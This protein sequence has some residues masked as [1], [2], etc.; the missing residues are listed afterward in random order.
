MSYDELPIAKI[1]FRKEKEPKSKSPRKPISKKNTER[2]AKRFVSD[3]GGTEYHEFLTSLPCDVCGVE[4]FTVAAH[5]K[6]RGAGGKA[7][8]TAPLCSTKLFLAK[9]ISRVGCHE[10]FDAHDPEIRKQEPRLR[11]LA[12]A[13]R[14]AFQFALSHAA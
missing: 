7:D 4:G 1:R 14:T 10:L 11:E 2:A 12:K 6:S 3:F 13:R 9:G 8:V 5:L